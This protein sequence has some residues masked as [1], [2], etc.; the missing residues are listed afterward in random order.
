M[1]GEGILNP[2]LFIMPTENA[3]NETDL[4]TFIINF[5]VVYNNKTFLFANINLVGVV[6]ILVL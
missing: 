1:S 4:T 2:V 3:N 6:F 5:A